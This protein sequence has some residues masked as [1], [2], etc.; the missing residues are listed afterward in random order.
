MTD[1]LAMGGHGGYIW[2]AFGITA[3]ILIGLLVASWRR[4][5]QR[6]TQLAELQREAGRR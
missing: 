2:P 6:E 4:V 3:L 5:R 1:F